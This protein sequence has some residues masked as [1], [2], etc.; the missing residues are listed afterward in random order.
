MKPRGRRGG[1]RAP[2]CPS[3][4]MSETALLASEAQSAFDAIFQD[5]VDATAS[6]VVVD[7]W[8]VATSDGCGLVRAAR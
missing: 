6:G 4:T 8:S 2:S 1:S 5:A 3:R 7:D